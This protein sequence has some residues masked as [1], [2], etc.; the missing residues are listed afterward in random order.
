MGRIAPSS[1]TCL[2]GASLRETTTGFTRRC[3]RSKQFIPASWTVTPMARASLRRLA[4]VKVMRGLSERLP[5]MRTLWKTSK[6]NRFSRS[7]F[8]VRA[9]ISHLPLMGFW[10]CTTSLG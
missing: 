6:G 2:M 1:I 8:M 10:M 3:T 9:V 7:S 5:S 4:I